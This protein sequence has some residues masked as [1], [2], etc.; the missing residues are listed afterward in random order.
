[1]NQRTIEKLEPLS[2]M[3]VT[4]VLIRLKEDGYLVRSGTEQTGHLEA[5][6]ERLDEQLL[7]LWEAAKLLEHSYFWLSRN[8]RRL[9][10]KPSRIGGKLLFERAD[11]RSLLK[12]QKVGKRGRPRAAEIVG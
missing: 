9:G 5:R 7:G 2:R 1:M 12:R 4:E 10:L 3:I 11:V 6:Q 8:Y